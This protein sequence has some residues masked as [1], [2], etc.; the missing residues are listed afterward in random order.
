MLDLDKITEEARRYV[1]GLSREEVLRQLAGHEAK[2]AEKKAK[3]EKKKALD[4][5][6]KAAVIERGTEL[7]AQ[8]EKEKSSAPKNN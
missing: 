8:E 1:S 4:K 2:E 5:A 7:R 3:A 6:I